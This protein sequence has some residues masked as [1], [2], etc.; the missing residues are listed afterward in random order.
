MIAHQDRLARFGYPLIA[1]LCET[2]QCE[3]I[4]MHT[5]AL[6]PEAEMVQDVM[7]IVDGFS[8]RLYGLRSY[9]KTLKEALAHGSDQDHS[10][11][12]PLEPNA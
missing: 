1:H 9:R 5:E 4:I 6:S 2:H 10:P 8:S 3:L 11:P 12:D 7:T